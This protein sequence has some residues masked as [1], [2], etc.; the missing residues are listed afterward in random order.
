MTFTDF[1]RVSIVSF[2]FRQ[3]GQ[4]QA[5]KTRFFRELYGYTQQVKQQLKNGKVV[6]RTYHYAGLLD[7]TPH[8]K[9]GKSVIGLQPGTEGPVISLLDSFDEVIYYNF[10]GWLPTTLWAE[11]D[12]VFL[13][14]SRLIERYGYLSVLVKLKQL[15]GH[16]EQKQIL[17][18]GF[19]EEFT[20]NAMNFLITQS[21]LEKAD[22]VVK[23]T[24]SGE[25]MANQFC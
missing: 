5:R 20:N 9:L 25:K 7:Q 22:G 12:E 19:D 13:E 11:K 8:V 10:I 21:W 1:R 17:D 15:G 18:A 14:T 16:G 2:D 3:Q 6:T 4:S 23:L 24:S